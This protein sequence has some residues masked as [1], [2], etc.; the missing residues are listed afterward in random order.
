MAEGLRIVRDKLGSRY[1]QQ[2][3]G[4]GRKGGGEGRKKEGHVTEFWGEDPCLWDP[5]RPGL[6]VRYASHK[7]TMFPP[8]CL[9]C[10]PCLPASLPPCLGLYGC[11]TGTGFVYLVPILFFFPP[12][13][14]KGRRKGG[15]GEREGR[16]EVMT[17]R[18]HIRYLV[19]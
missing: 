1:P 4:E 3:E 8:S 18:L 16:R 7:L 2:R 9:P 17:V 11:F 19:R 15:R 6:H 10:L 14:M 12:C 5:G 13:V